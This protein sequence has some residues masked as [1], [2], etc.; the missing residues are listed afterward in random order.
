[1]NPDHDH[2]QR[3]GRINYAGYCAKSPTGR[4]YDGSP[5]K[6]WEQLT[7][8]IRAQWQAGAEAVLQGGAEA[9]LQGGAAADEQPTPRPSPTGEPPPPPR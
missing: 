7:D 3:L 9:V 1:M 6:A 8:A 2:D 4:A 5:L